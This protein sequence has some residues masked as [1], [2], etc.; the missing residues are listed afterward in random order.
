MTW[1]SVSQCA[2]CDESF[3]LVEDSEQIFTCKSINEVIGNCEEVQPISK[4]KHQCTKCKQNFVLDLEKNSCDEIPTENSISNCWNYIYSEDHTIIC[5][6]C[7]DYHIVSSD[8]Q[9]CSELNTQIFSQYCLKG[10]THKFPICL[11][12][13]WGHYYKDGECLSCGIDGCAICEL[14]DEIQCKVCKRGWYM[15]QDKQCIYDPPS[16]VF[17]DVDEEKKQLAWF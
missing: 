4:T 17:F 3:L 7:E 10:K 15:N 9:S 13:H 6:E 12:C 11:I 5:Q 16:N 14:H 1:E 8:N 2:S